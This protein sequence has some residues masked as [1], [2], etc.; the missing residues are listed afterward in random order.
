MIDYDLLT[1]SEYDSL[2]IDEFDTMPISDWGYA[3]AE[4]SELLFGTEFLKTSLLTD[5]SN[6]INV[7][8]VESGFFPSNNKLF[9]QG[10]PLSLYQ[11]A[12]GVYVLDVIVVFSGTHTSKKFS[13]KGMPIAPVY[14]GNNLVMA[15]EYK[16]FTSIAK[17]TCF[18]GIHLGVTNNRSLC[19]HD[20]ELGENYD[21][22]SGILIGQEF[23]LI[24]RHGSNWRLVVSVH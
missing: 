17:T 11:N 6:L 13:I 5:R 16:Q 22:Q 23:A 4:E 19:L 21:E 18:S 1:I 15:V 3:V 24:R 9:W 14:R 8:F 2:T 7:C 10:M 12:S 20:S